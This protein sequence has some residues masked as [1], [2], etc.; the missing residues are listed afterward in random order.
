[1]AFLNQKKTLLEIK[2]ET[3]GGMSVIGEGCDRK[4]AAIVDLFVFNFNTYITVNKQC[5]GGLQLCSAQIRLAFSL[6]MGLALNQNQFFHEW[7]AD[8]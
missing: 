2:A 3:I 5:P 7:S 1:M 6:I 4:F 8:G